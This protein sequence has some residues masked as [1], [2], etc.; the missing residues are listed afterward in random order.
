[1]GNRIM[2]EKRGFCI[3]FVALVFLLPSLVVKGQVFSTLPDSVFLVVDTPPQFPGGSWEMVRFIRENKR[4]PMVLSTPPIDQLQGI[5]IVEFTVT[6]TGK[7]EDVEITRRFDLIL[8]RVAVRLVESMP[9]WIPGKLNGEKVNVRYT[10]PIKF[11]GIPTD[12]EFTPLFVETPQFPGGEEALRSFLAEN[13]LM[14][15]E[16]QNDMLN[17]F[18]TC[19]FRVETSG[20]IPR[21]DVFY[22]HRRSDPA[23]ENQLREVLQSMPDWIP[24]VRNGTNISTVH[25]FHVR[26]KEETSSLPIEDI[27]EITE[28]RAEFPGGAPELFSFI[29]R[30]MFRYVPPFISLVYMPQGR[31][32][33][34]FVIRKDGSITDIEVVRSSDPSLNREAIRIVEAMPKW[35]PAKQNGEKVNSRF[36][37]P[38]MFRPPF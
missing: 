5:V 27:Y 28:I 11:S 13:S 8:E 10:L 22:S 17:G 36:T 38:I 6:R 14:L 24:V 16:T 34:Q 30:E 19:V 15:V 21:I 23:K 12:R 1:M 25:S 20:R 31:V 37:L 3:F 9:K 33:V 18:F 32:A 2:I 26:F 4:I 29:N 35:I 7:I